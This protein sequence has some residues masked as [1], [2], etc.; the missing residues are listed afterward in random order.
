S[1]L[2]PRP[3]YR[4]PLNMYLTVALDSGELK[5]SVKG[6][7]FAPVD[8]CERALR[9]EARRQR[10]VTDAARVL[11]G[12]RRAKEKDD[13]PAVD[14]YRTGV[15]PEALGH[16]LHRHGG[17]LAIVSTEAGPLDMMAGRYRH[18]EMP[19]IDIYLNAFSGESIKV[20]RVSR[21]PDYV[22]HATLT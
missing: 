10:E 2:Q 18:R 15:T 21:E 8:R 5:S 22:D 20:H 3:G 4:E 19:N 17:R 11:D 6:V 14:L 16:E 13:G 1:F 7:V 9:E 12:G